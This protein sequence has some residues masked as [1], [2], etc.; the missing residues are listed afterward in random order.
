MALVFTGMNSN[1]ANSGK[2]LWGT[3]RQLLVDN[4]CKL[5]LKGNPR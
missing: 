5:G 4:A 2:A 1:F 3:A